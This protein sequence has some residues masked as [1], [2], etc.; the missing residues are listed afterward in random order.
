MSRVS[1]GLKPPAVKVA[2]LSL[3]E[4]HGVCGPNIDRMCC[5]RA[6]DRENLF[7]DIVLHFGFTNTWV[8]IVVPFAGRVAC[9]FAVIATGAVERP[10][11]Y[12]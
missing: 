1:R 6:N 4:S 5:I 8:R 9:S 12:N 10:G 7:C 11:T 2:S 3:G